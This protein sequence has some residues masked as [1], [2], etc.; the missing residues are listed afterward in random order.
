MTSTIIFSGF[1]SNSSFSAD[2]ESTV[3]AYKL[4]DVV[5]NV[6]QKKTGPALDLEA[7]KEALKKLQSHR[8]ENESLLSE[9]YDN[10]TP[11]RDPI[12]IY[13]D[14]QGDLPVIKVTPTRPTTIAFLREDGEPVLI[15]TPVTK[16]VGEEGGPRFSVSPVSQLEH[17]YKFETTVYKGET[18]VDLYFK[19]ATFPITV[20]VVAGMEYHASAKAIVL[21][22]SRLIDERFESGGAVKNITGH[23]Q[24]LSEALS[25]LV[26]SDTPPKHST[27]ISLIAITPG[28]IKRPAVRLWR[29]KVGDQYYYLF[30]TPG[31]LNKP[32]FIESMP[33]ISVSNRKWAYAV[34]TDNLN[35]IISITY[36]G[37]NHTYAVYRDDP[38][39]D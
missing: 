27:E 11:I 7:K 26:N 19:D 10:V 39:R 4:D 36:S 35:N 28:L 8:V 13:M 12:F 5:R 2:A 16:D 20:K 1:I 22:E 24:D 21:D 32:N 6:L 34:P 29:S 38:I 23:T 31:Y 30:K 33:S 14:G 15:G 9:A 18:T 25:T 37:V 3:L 17:V